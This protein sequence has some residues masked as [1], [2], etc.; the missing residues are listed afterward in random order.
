VAVAAADLD[1]EEG[2]I[3]AGL[4]DRRGPDVPIMPQLG[5]R[6]RRHIE[7]GRPKGTTSDRIF[8]S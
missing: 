7:R 6:L 8:V 2:T 1:E 3:Q 5:R 4:R